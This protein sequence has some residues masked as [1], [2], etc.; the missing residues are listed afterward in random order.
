[1]KNTNFLILIGVGLLISLYEVVSTKIYY[2][3]VYCEKWCQLGLIISELV[4]MFMLLAN[5]TFIKTRYFRIIRAAISIIIIGVLFKIMHWEYS[6]VIFAVGYLAI[7]GI[8]SKSFYE[9]SPKIRLDY[10]KL[11]WLVMACLSVFVIVEHLADHGYRILQSIL[12]WLAV[13]DYL[14]TEWENDTL[15]N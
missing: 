8:Y 1:M 4:G 15:F 9:K 5:G 13:I 6:S 12:L 14:K 7:I 2:G 11:A 3:E 10:L